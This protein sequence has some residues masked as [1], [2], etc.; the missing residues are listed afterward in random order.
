[1]V[2]NIYE[3]E[4]L[5]EGIFADISGYHWQVSITQEEAIEIPQDPKRG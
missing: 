3:M 5:F 2:F 4:E 1:M